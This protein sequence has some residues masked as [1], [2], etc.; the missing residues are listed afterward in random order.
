MLNA[1]G[2]DYE[3]I[4]SSSKGLILKSSG[5]IK[6]QWGKKFIDLLDNN[7]NVNLSQFKD[8]LNSFIQVSQQNDGTMILKIDE[9]E[10]QLSG[11]SD[12]TITSII[13]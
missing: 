13:V 6:I 8:K 4:G 5:K 9:E 12:E 2:R 11:I 10:I 7:G 3:E 1:F